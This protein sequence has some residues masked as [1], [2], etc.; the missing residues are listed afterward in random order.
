MRDTIDKLLF[1]INEICVRGRDD[2]E[3][4]ILYSCFSSLYSALDAIK[5]IESRNGKG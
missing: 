5:I 1:Y 2:F 4:G 3:I